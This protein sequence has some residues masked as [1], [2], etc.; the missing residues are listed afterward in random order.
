LFA[1]LALV[2]GAVGIYGV[3]SYSVAQRTRELGIRIAL[4]ARRAELLLM[5]LREGAKLAFAGVAIGLLGALLLTKLMA[6]LLY[7]VGTRDPL[8]YASVG[9][10]LVFVALIASYLP[11]RRATRVDPVVALRY[12]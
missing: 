2:L 10:L 9:V 11:A 6:S 1:G 5:I 12:E 4:G 7:G 3:I 8:T